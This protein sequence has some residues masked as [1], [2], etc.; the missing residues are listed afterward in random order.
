MQ[1]PVFCLLPNKPV[2][3][4]ELDQFFYFLFQM[5]NVTRDAP[6]DTTLLNPRTASHL[7]AHRLAQAWIT[8]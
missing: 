7:Q 5:L 2:Y 4:E 3:Y 6:D 8:C 1:Q